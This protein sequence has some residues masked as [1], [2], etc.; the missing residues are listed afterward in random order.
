MKSQESQ[1][2]RILLFEDNGLIRSM[3]GRLLL[4]QGWEVFSF[5]DP[6][7][8]PLQQSPS[9]GCHL[10]EVCADAI[11]TDLEMPHIDGYTFVRDLLQKG[12]RIHNLAMLTDSQDTVLLERATAFGFAVFTKSEGT[13]R[14]LEWLR[15]IEAHLQAERQ[16]THW[17]EA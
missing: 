9:C 5:P 15:G 1:R 8:C 2:L 17:A 3:L 10:P 12:C 6:E 11:V 4:K 7:V 14:L 13:S 16:L